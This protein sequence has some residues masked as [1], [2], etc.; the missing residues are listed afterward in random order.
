MPGSTIPLTPESDLALLTTEQMGDAD[1]IAIASGIPGID[2]MERAG[3]AVAAAAMRHAAPGARAAV[4]CG[5][6]NNGGDGFVAARIL[7]ERGYQVELALFGEAKA[8]SGDAATAAERWGGAVGPL[9]AVAAEH[10]DIVIDA[11]FGAGL[12]RP[13][14]GEAALAVEAMNASGRPVIAVDV[15]SGLS[16]DTGQA[17]GPVVRAAETVTFFRLKP[18]HLLQPGRDLCGQ[19]T[20]VDIGIPA[21]AALGTIAPK[22]FANRASLWND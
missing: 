18:G 7:R 5:P 4:L 1:R 13:L 8:L 16:G 21:G 22:A 19:V 2:L 9:S 20:L 15:P 17:E 11:L 10:A 6:G 12:S 3:A 14:A